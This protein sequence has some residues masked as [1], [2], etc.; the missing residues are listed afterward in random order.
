METNTIVKYRIPFTFVVIVFFSIS[1]PYYYFYIKDH[2]ISSIQQDSLAGEQYKYVITSKCKAV[3]AF[4][5]APYISVHLNNFDV[6]TVAL[7]QGFDTLGDC[8]RSSTKD[9]QLFEAEGKI[10]V[11]MVSGQIKEINIIYD[12]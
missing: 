7:H 2:V 9:M 8:M 10:K 4:T 5:F 11:Y 1:V 3:D 6:L 12:R